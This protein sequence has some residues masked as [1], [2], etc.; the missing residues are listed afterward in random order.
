M[1]RAWIVC[2]AVGQRGLLAQSPVVADPLKG[3]VQSCN[4]LEVQANS[5]V[6]V[7]TDSNNHATHFRALSYRIVTGMIG[8]HTLLALLHAVVAR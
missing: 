7:A 3:I 1:L 8:A 6:K 4:T 2:T 5:A